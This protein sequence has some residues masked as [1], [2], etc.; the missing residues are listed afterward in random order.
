MCS[1]REWDSGRQEYRDIRD[2][3][4]TGIIIISGVFVNGTSI[5]SSGGTLAG[6]R[7]KVRGSRVV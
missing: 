1:V 6:S 7:V 4:A 5:H 2:G 3:W